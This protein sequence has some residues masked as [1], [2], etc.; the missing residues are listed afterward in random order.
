MLIAKWKCRCLA[1]EVE[2]SLRPRG[3]IEDISV[4]MEDIREAVTIDHRERSPL[5]SSEMLEY[6]KIPLLKE[7]IGD[8]PTKH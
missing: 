2:I 3:P 4:W 1:K 6:L 5:C 8:A 7:R